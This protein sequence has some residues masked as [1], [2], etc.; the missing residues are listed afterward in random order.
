MKR[1]ITLFFAVVAAFS[2][3]SQTYIQDGDRCFDSGDYIC[4]EAKYNEEFKSTT[5]KD[6]Q[7]AEIKLSRARWCG[8]YLKIA[9][10]EFA[11][12]NYKA[13]KENYLSVLESNPKDSYV[14]TQLGKC[15]DLLKPP[16]T[17]LGVSKVNLRFSFSGGNE[18]IAVTTNSD[19][20]LLNALPSWC[21]V[22]KYARYFTITC[23]DNPASTIRTGY[24]TVSA[25]AKTVRVDITQAAKTKTEITLSVSNRDI[26]FAS[27]GGRTI[28]DVKTNTADYQ[29]INLPSWCKVGAK[30][31]NWFSLTC[32]ANV[33]SGSRLSW[34]KV[35]AGDKEIKIEVHQSGPSQSNASNP[36]ENQSNT[37]SLYKQKKTFNSPNAKY[38]WGISLGYVNKSVARSFGYN[39]YDDIKMDGIQIGLRFEPLFK[40][41]FGLNTGLFYEYYALNLFDDKY[42][43][44]DDYKE[45]LISIPLHLEYRFNLSKYFNIFAYGG[46]SMDV[47]TN[48]YFDD[49]SFQTS[50]DYGGGIRIDHFQVNVGQNLRLDKFNDLQR[51]NNLKK[52]KNLI[53]SLS[54]MF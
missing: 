37:N 48:G 43:T 25:G 16:V 26:S 28:I 6:R 2:A 52:Y 42:D 34:F 7:N 19:S 3:Y 30:H 12:K 44:D 46:A 10:Q 39:D 54:Y 32:D 51:I 5:G 23:K 22:Q 8:K 17:T 33:T 9:N 27:N 13:A 4:A 47:I 31:S 15:D 11:N 49:Y 24:F 20:Y 14:K 38:P 18:D 50:L 53:V 36:G 41:G 35:S 1:V 29:I 45:H 40:Y 21:T